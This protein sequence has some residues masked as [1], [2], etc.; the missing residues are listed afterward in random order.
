MPLT[1]NMNTD[2]ARARAEWYALMKEYGLVYKARNKQRM[3]EINTR[4]EKLEDIPK[5][6]QAVPG[7][8]KEASK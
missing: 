7:F 3:V 4:L 8:D 2:R 1:D 5:I 6:M